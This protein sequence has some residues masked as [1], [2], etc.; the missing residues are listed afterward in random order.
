MLDLT[1]KKMPSAV[2][3][4]GILYP[5]HTDY[6]YYLNLDKIL[7]KKDF[8]PSDIDF[9]FTTKKPLEKVAGVEALLDFYS[10]KRILPI[11]SGETSERVFDYMIDADLIYAAFY[12]V[13]KIDLIDT[14]LH[15]WKFLALFDGVIGT[16]FNDITG[17]RGFDPNDKTSYEQSMKNL[18]RAWALPA[19]M[20][21]EE[22]EDFD[23]F[24][25]LFS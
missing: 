25:K 16:R 8:Q 11:S 4:G 9:L 23:N 14:D 2:E 15:W 6:R 19:E 22:K 10:P 3:V 13:Y 17:Y 7:K 18:K 24:N 12:Q 20:N 5:I 1:K 21:E